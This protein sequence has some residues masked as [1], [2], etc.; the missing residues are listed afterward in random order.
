MIKEAHTLLTKQRSIPL[1]CSTTPQF[2]LFEVRSMG[3]KTR[4][5]C[6]FFP[7]ILVIKSALKL[8]THVHMGG[9]RVMFTEW[10]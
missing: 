2:K 5:A 9:Q 4:V 8:N 6:K 3:G 7:F 10:V 1:Q